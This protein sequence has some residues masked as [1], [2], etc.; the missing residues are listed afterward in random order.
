VSATLLKMCL[1]HSGPLVYSSHSPQSVNFKIKIKRISK[2]YWQF[3][4]WTFFYLSLFERNLHNSKF[5]V[6]TAMAPLHRVAKLVQIYFFVLCIYSYI[7]HRYNEFTTKQRIVKPKSQCVNMA[8][9]LAC[10]WTA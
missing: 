9:Y 1:A 3:F 5:D 4:I 6:I 2:N 7:S 8:P 10:S